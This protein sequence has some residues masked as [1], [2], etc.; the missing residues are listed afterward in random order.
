MNNK[1]YT[2]LV[3][4]LACSM[5]AGTDTAPQNEQ[6]Q[7]MVLTVDLQNDFCQEPDPIPTRV[8]ERR[9]FFF[10]RE[11]TVNIQTGPG[12]LAVPGTDEQY[13]KAVINFMA[14]L[15]ERNFRIGHTQDWHTSDNISFAS[16]PRWKAQD[17][18]AFDQVTTPNG[19][20]QTLW[21]NHCVQGT[22]G[23][24]FIR[25]VYQKGDLVQQKGQ[26]PKIDSYSGFDDNAGNDTGLDAKLRAA[27]IN[28]LIIFGLATDYC[29]NFTMDG[30]LKRGN[31][32][33]FVLN[34]SRGITRDG[35]IAALLNRQKYALENER[36][37][38]VSY[39]TDANDGMTEE[40]VQAFE[41]AGVNVQR[42]KTDEFLK[43][44]S[45]RTASS[46][47]QRIK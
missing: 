14:K 40:E 34:L 17:K 12:A 18:K 10:S 23:A 37:F 43:R 38:T 11:K 8:K 3:A 16:N 46:L 26:D 9:L 20:D 28:T 32:T 31:K 29:D 25:G 39:L 27:Q 47:T 41:K 1:L 21:P 15:R 44:F 45:P 30:S 33:H 13:K 6:D 2:L 4:S 19:Q 7:V 5:Y 42:A 22:H 35:S 24:E 36:I